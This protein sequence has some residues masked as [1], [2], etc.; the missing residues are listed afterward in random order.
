MILESP[1]SSLPG[2][3]I[4]MGIPSIPRPEVSAGHYRM[5][6]VRQRLTRW[7]QPRCETDLLLRPQ[8]Q[9]ERRSFDSAR[10]HKSETGVIF[11]EKAIT[12]GGQGHSGSEPLPGG[13][14]KDCTN[15]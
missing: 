14:Y 8:N 12:P 15:Q 13:C 4:L 1:G 10:N 5:E 9:K 7:L 2:P 3:H 6:R 11:H